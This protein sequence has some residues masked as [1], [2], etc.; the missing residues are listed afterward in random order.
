[1]AL[2]RRGSYYKNK[3]GRRGRSSGQGGQAFSGDE[4]AAKRHK[5]EGGGKLQKLDGRPYPAYRDV[6]HASTGWAIPSGG[7]LVA[8]SI[9]SD[10]YASPSR[11]RLI[12]PHS[13]S[14]FP[15]HLRSNPTRATALAHYLSTTLYN[16][17]R[18]PQASES[19]SNGWHAPRGGV[20]TVDKPGQQV[21]PRTSVKITDAHIEA[22]FTVALPARGRTIMGDAAAILFRD[23]VPTLALQLLQTNHGLDALTHFVDCIEDQES[24]RSQ[25]RAAGLAAFVANG[26]ILPRASGASDLPLR[27]GRVTAFASP[28]SLAHTL[29]LPHRGAV[30]GMGIPQGVTM[31]AGGGFH[32]KSTLLAALAKGCYNHVPGDG[33]EFVATSPTCTSVQGEDG[34]AITGVD[35]SA[36][37]D[38]LPG[39]VS[40]RSF[41]TQDASGSTSM[42]AGVIEAVELGADT[43]LFDE[44][45]CATNFLIRDARMQRLISADPITPLVFR[46]RALARTAGV[47]S[48]LVIGG[49]GDY[50]DVADTVLEMREYACYD[51][52]ARAK[53]VASEL[54]SV[55]GQAE[56]L[57][58]PTVIPRPLPRAFL[59]PAGSK[60]HARG[61]A[62]VQLHGELSLD[63]SKLVQLTHDSQT[64]AIAGALRSLASH[65]GLTLSDALRALYDRIAQDGLDAL[66]DGRPDGFLVLPRLLEVGMAV[67]RLRRS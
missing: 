1:M 25:L 6:F 54:P 46:V 15:H 26:S 2:R 5:P 22:R 28:P 60:V 40:T 23:D 17:V 18:A 48:I 53:E 19:T 11:M 55:V 34:R 59:P 14:A 20:L 3:Y 24:L 49:C 45:T 43:L 39:G 21:L 41:S 36:F 37:I 16:A 35:I 50:C 4:P 9:Q 30:T 44:D 8:D 65:P 32:G 27:T 57:T 58:F 12:V 64:R 51:I 38:N 62:T 29:K 42:A 10:P 33:R 56:V 7:S 52:T 63:L 67:N 13:T 31:I 61:R 47:S 66:G